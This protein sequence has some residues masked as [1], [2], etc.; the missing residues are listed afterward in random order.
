MLKVAL[1]LELMWEVACKKQVV[2]PLCVRIAVGE[3]PKWVCYFKRNFDSKVTAF[4]AVSFEEIFI[5]VVGVL[6]V[7]VLVVISRKMWSIGERSKRNKKSNCVQQS[8]YD[9]EFYSLLISTDSH[10]SSYHK[11]CKNN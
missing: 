6:R 11:E 7:L 8:G 5:R 2:S 4:E 10:D 1:I 3:E 9:V